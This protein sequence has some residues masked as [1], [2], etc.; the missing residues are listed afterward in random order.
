MTIGLIGRKVGMTRLYDGA[1]RVRPVTVLEFEANHVTQLRTAERDGYVAVQVGTRGDRK[2]LTR[3]ERGHLRRAGV[4]ARATRLRE[5]RVDDAGD[6]APGGTLTV[7][8]FE[9]GQFVN[10]AG[11]TKG[12]GFA[13]GVRRWNFRGGPKTHGQSDRHRAPGS[14]GA[15]TTP[16]KVWKGQKMAGHMGARQQTT[17]NL[18]VVQVD[19]ARNLLFVQ[20]AVPGHADA[21]VTVTPGRRK[22]IADFRAPEPLALPDL[23]EE[24]TTSAPA[25]EESAAPEDGAPEDSAAE[26][27]AAPEGSAAEDSAAEDSVAEASAP[28]A[29][30]PE[31]SAAGDDAADGGAT[32]DGDAAPADGAAADDDAEKAE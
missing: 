2:R 32:G 20:G 7:E 12:R 22:P 30:A 18:L 13:G 24:E 19:A 15:G 1:G 17:L 21:L 8:Q 11:V 6:L 23:A 27:S 4:D 28:E 10:V 29:S 3:P 31:A 16:G 9:P 25:A 5:F 26:D 14:I